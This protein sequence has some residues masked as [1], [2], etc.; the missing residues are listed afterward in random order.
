MHHQLR[1]RR[2]RARITGTKNRPRMSVFISDKNISVQLIDDDSQ[3]TLVYASTVGSKAKGTMTERAASVGSEVATK[4]KS[5]KIK[6]VVLD[7]NGRL[8]HGRIKALADAA[9]AGG[10][11]F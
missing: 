9:R 11:E 6:Q 8:Y 2:I 1:K 3:K 7:R 4:A 5:A 10:L